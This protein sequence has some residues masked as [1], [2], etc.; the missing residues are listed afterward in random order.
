MSGVAGNPIQSLSKFCPHNQL[1]VNYLSH[2]LLT[3]LLLP[4]IKRGAATARIVNV[5]CS[6]HK[7]AQVDSK[8][9][10]FP[11]PIILILVLTVCQILVDD[12]NLNAKYCRDQAYSQ[13]KLAIV[14]FSAELGRRLDNC[15]GVNVYCVNPGKMNLKMFL[16]FEEVHQ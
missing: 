7:E 2:F 12:L 16:P 9:C 6:R 14:M 15:S 1:G 11:F 3:L 8:H 5:S 10:S 13:S 4:V